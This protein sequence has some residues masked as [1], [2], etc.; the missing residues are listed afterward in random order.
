M[1]VASD[2]CFTIFCQCW[3]AHLLQSC[4]APLHYI[5]YILFVIVILLLFPSILSKPSVCCAYCVSL[6]ELSHTCCAWLPVSPSLGCFNLFCLHCRAFDVCNAVDVICWSTV[7]RQ[8]C[9]SVCICA[10]LEPMSWVPALMWCLCGWRLQPAGL[11]CSSTSGH[12]LLHSFWRTEISTDLD[13]TQPT[14]SL[15][16]SCSVS[17]L[18]VCVKCGFYIV[19][20]LQQD[21]KALEK[22]SVLNMT[23]VNICWSIRTHLYSTIL[24]ANHRRIHL[25]NHMDVKIVQ[26]RSISVTSSFCKLL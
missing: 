18:T 11:A 6:T 14:C 12:S 13:V 8:S 17:L 10:G 26:Y 1:P 25:I 9:W 3:V 24:Q 21:H 5:V 15:F 23:V 2:A 7:K 22:C 19:W 16:F 4:S 20:I